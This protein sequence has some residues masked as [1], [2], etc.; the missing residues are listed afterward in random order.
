MAERASHPDRDRPPPPPRR[1]DP[2]ISEEED[3][4][5]EALDRVTWRVGRTLMVGVPTL[6]ALL[7]LV[8]TA[9]PGIAPMPAL[10]IAVLVTGVV[11]VLLE[12]RRARRRPKAAG[13]SWLTRPSGPTIAV[14]A[15]SGAVILLYTLLIV[16]VG[17]R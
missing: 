3:R 12:R 5:L 2:G 8:P 7:I 14:L 13:G 6:V 15:A 10:A 4:F 11:C 1:P 16:A 9:I 17:G